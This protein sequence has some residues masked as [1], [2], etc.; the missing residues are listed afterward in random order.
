[1]TEPRTI[2]LTL[3]GQILAGLVVLGMFVLLGG[4]FVFIVLQRGIVDDQRHIALRQENR[5]R[6]VLGTADALLGSPR[7]ALAAAREAGDAL[8]DLR[9]V[10]RQ[11]LD[12][13]V[14]GVTSK[15]LRRAPELLA[16]VDRAMRILERTYPTL[17]ASL[18]VQRRSLETQRASLAIQRESLRT[19]RESLAIQRRTFDLLQRSYDVQ[20]GTQAIAAETRDIARQTLVHTESID[21]K[22]GGT[23]PPLVP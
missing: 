17:R 19:Q 15:A 11:A 13:D 12:E 14:V 21:R 10:L 2:K 9:R 8:A 20:R 18:S 23:A 22:T 6:P 5:A 7:E 16:A 1:M 4:Q 3:R